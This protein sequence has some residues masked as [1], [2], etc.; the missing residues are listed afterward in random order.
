MQTEGTL[1]TKQPLTGQSEMVFKDDPS[2][3]GWDEILVQKGDGEKKEGGEGE[4]K[5]P[6]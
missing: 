4:E 2:E 6:S 1:I 5:S 3:P